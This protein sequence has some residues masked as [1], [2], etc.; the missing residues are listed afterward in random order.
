MNENSEHSWNAIAKYYDDENTFDN[1]IQFY[2]R[3]AP[4]TPGPVLELGCGTGRVSIPF[5]QAGYHVTGIDFSSQMLEVYNAKTTQLSAE[6]SARITTYQHSI[7]AYDLGTRFEL[8]LIPFNTL[9]LVTDFRAQEQV[10]LTAKKHLTPSGTL[11]C[12]VFNPDLELITRKFPLVKYAGSW[13]DS[14][15][16]RDV[17]TFEVGYCDQANQL[18][19]G[20][21][22]YD[23]IDED[24]YVLRTR[25]VF[26]VRYFFSYELQVLL[27]KTGFVPQKLYG[28]FDDSTFATHSPHIIFECTAA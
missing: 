2:L 28:D 7:D 23:E 6:E 22:Y 14:A 13:K 25:H 10:L 11:L 20:I 15:S 27:E 16:G 4:E 9:C 26:E 5:A 18:I 24:G 3:H 1:D 21:R 19:Y 12:T 17:D 8:I